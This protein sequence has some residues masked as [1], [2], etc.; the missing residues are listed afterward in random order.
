MPA[1]VNHVLTFRL[2]DDPHLHTSMKVDDYISGEVC[3]ELGALGRSGQRLQHCFNLVGV[4]HDPK[5]ESWSY[6]MRQTAAYFSFDIIR[7]R[8]TWVIIKANDTIRS[9]IINASTKSRMQRRCLGNHKDPK[10]SFLTA[11][12]THLLIF[13]WSVEQWGNYIE[14]LEEQLRGPSSRFKLSSVEEM[15]SDDRIAEMVD[16]NREYHSAIRQGTGLSEHSQMSRNSVPGFRRTTI[17]RV[18]S[19]PV[20]SLN[21]AV[22]PS[23]PLTRPRTNE[24]DLNK[25]YSFD[26]FQKLYRLSGKM[27]DARSTISRD[28]EVLV[29]MLS[30]F[31]S[32]TSSE[33]FKRHVQVDHNNMDEFFQGTE[34]CLRELRSYEGRIRGIMSRLDQVISLVSDNRRLL[35]ELYSLPRHYLTI[36]SLM[37]LC[38]TKIC[39]RTSSLPSRPKSRQR[40][41]KT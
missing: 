19:V 9:R 12:D 21:S 40:P 7:G 39:A 30:R 6:S 38:S 26:E 22:H 25:I 41:W 10:S 36:V 24:I 34:W 33:V 32:L 35:A 27:E 13:E 16:G 5:E 18:S 1:F 14:F 4:E 23:M 31:K 15:T 11:L 37:Q 8:S 2:R 28:T 20:Q 29:E 3:N 17:S